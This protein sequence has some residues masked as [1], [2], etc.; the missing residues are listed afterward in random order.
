MVFVQTVDTKYSLGELIRRI[1]NS[2]E[3]LN[4]YIKEQDGASDPTQRVAALTRIIHERLRLQILVKKFG[5]AY[6]DVVDRNFREVATFVLRNPQYL[7]RLESLNEQIE[8]NLKWFIKEESRERRKSHYLRIY[9]KDLLGKVKPTF[10]S[11]RRQIEKLQKKQQP[12]YS[13][14]HEQERRRKLELL[15]S[16]GF[17][18]PAKEKVRI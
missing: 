6:L 12:Q 15:K 9:A 10:K 13:K 17:L 2:S 8:K 1:H 14:K 3:F 16:K 18:S 7:P 4:K 11:V 5:K